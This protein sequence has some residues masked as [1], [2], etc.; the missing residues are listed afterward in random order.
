MAGTHLLEFNSMTERLLKAYQDM[1]FFPQ[2]V[3][4]NAK[5]IVSPPCAGLQDMA[6]HVR[7]LNAGKSVINVDQSF[8]GEYQ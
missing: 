6:R 8:V 2:G 3:P 5:W 7:K 1:I 4:I